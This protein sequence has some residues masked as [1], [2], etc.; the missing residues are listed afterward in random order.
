MKL[1]LYVTCF[2][3]MD[4]VLPDRCGSHTPNR[5]MPPRPFQYEVEA[6]DSIETDADAAKADT[7]TIETVAQP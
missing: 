1:F 4:V 6:V 5:P 3:L 7:T 2:V